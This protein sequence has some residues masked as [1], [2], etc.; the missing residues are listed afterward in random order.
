MTEYDATQKQRTM[1]RRIRATKR[2]LA[3]YDAGIGATDSEALKEELQTAFDR[4]AVL[5]KRQ[6]AALKDFT[7]QTGLARDRAREQVSAH[8]EAVQGKT[9][10]FNK[11]VSQESI[12]VVM[13]NQKFI[14]DMEA[15]GIHTEGFERFA[16]KADVLY[17]MKSVYSKISE[18][19][20][21]EI[22]GLTIRYAFDKDSSTFGWYD[23]TKNEISFNRNIF[24][25]RSKLIH[26]YEDGAKNGHFPQGTDYRACF[27]HEF[28]HCFSNFHNIDNKALVEACTEEYWHGHYTRKKANEMLIRS[29][30]EYSTELTRP[31]FQE[32]FAESF[33]EW[34]NSKNPREFCEKYLRMAG[35]I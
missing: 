3:G 23:K 18:N 32:V 12:S 7:K 26:E 25:T 20:P 15:I 10:A 5:L 30:S 35:V 14:A 21:K 2:E 17:D 1:E 4:K 34:Y 19:F 31:Q 28:G 29:L 16:G 22:Q 33:A 13:R 8:F 11:S 9:V 27:Y 24:D 6:E